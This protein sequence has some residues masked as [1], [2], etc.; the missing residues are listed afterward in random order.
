MVIDNN[1]NNNDVDDDDDELSQ[2]KGG[3]AGSC[4]YNKY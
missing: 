3:R 2:V 4:I 1:S